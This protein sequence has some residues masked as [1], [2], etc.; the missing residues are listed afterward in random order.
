[1]SEVVGVCRRAENELLIAVNDD[2][3]AADAVNPFTRIL[4]RVA[5]EVEVPGG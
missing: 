4:C 2:S 5:L 3:S 1:M